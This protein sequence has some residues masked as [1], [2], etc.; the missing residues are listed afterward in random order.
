MVFNQFLI[1]GIIVFFLYAYEIEAVR[2]ERYIHIAIVE[3]RLQDKM[4]AEI[5]K[6]N[7]SNRMRGCDCEEICGGIRVYGRRKQCVSADRQGL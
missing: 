5:V 6:E 4:T 1:K 2:Q 7:S 3:C